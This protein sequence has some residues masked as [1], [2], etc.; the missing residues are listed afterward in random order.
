MFNSKKRNCQPEMMDDPLID[1]IILQHAVDD[2]TKINHL[3]GGFKF[4]L[5]AVKKVIKQHPDKP[6]T[7][8]D[9][10]CGDG[11]MLRYLDAHIHG[12]HMRFVGV[13]L[14]PLSIEKARKKSVGLS[15]V[16]FRESDILNLH[17]ATFTCDILTSTLTMHHFNDEQIV[18]FLK[19]FK[20][21][22]SM[23][24]IINDLHRSRLAYVFFKYFS[25]IFIKHHISRH[26]G[27]ISIAAGFKRVDFKKYAQEIAVNNDLVL[28]KWS[29]RFL[30][31]IPTYER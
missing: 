17:T 7:I 24:I 14:S 27:L 20:Q 12:D 8:V 19:K 28:W 16:S 3:L 26:D 4:T 6:L 5:D 18:T 11:A 31:I 25:P 30:W 9:A 10:G 2:I 1:P 29:F 13:D 23:A 22:A 15:R 21:L